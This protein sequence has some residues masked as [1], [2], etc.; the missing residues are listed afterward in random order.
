MPL[1]RGPRGGCG[2]LSGWGCWP[3]R[4]VQGADA[5]ER[6]RPRVVLLERARS[7]GRSG[8]ELRRVESSRERRRRPG[9]GRIMLAATKVLEDP[10]NHAR[11][12]DG[13]DETNL[14]GASGTA[15]ELDTPDTLE[16]SHPAHRGAAGGGGVLARVRAGVCG[17]AGDDERT[18]ARP[19]GKQAVVSNQVGPGPRHQRGEAGLPPRLAA[20]RPD[21][22]PY[23]AVDGPGSGPAA[24]AVT[25]EAARR[26]RKS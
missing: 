9:L 4:H 12:G 11:L 16:A 3:T 5:L 2:R 25:R 6:R 10:R 8:P 26:K 20:L 23:C 24:R 7:P 19:R 15:T 17:G 13:G 14:A 1:G 22:L 18:V 21:V